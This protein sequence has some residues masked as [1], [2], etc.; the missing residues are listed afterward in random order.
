MTGR[1]KGG[2]GRTPLGTKTGPAGV[3]GGR[4]GRVTRVDTDVRSVD[5]EGRAGT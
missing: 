2:G 1:E 5:R 3:N 4:L